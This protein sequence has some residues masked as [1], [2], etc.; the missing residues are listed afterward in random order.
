RSADR[1]AKSR[2]NR[3]WS[4]SAPELRIEPHAS[5]PVPAESS[6]LTRARVRVRRPLRRS[7]QSSRVVSSIAARAQASR[8]SDLMGRSILP[9]LPEQTRDRA[10]NENA[11]Q[12]SFPDN[13]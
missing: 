11:L 13:G 6:R 10:L 8:L 9:A 1:P 3:K 12:D 4:Y 7:R 2:R 5:P